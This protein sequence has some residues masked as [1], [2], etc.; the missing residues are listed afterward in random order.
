MK[1][2]NTWYSELVS[3]EK[4]HETMS[5][6]HRGKDLKEG[7]KII[8]GEYVSDPNNFNQPIKEHR[9]HLH[10]K[11]LKQPIAPLRH[12]FVEQKKEEPK[13]AFASNEE[14]E[15]YL[16]EWLGL[17]KQSKTYVP[18][19]MTHS[20]IVEEGG[21]L[22]KKKEIGYD[23]DYI[24]EWRK[25]VAK[26]QEMTVRE[27]HPDWTEEQIQARLIELRTAFL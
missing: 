24:H 7:A 9:R 22:P 2:F 19:K 21:W 3:D 17:L 15:K 13:T 20:E 8:Y 27:R 5:M 18:P 14:R 4:W 26:F 25:K 6:L 23:K 12:E 16:N 1:D 11:M 10:Y